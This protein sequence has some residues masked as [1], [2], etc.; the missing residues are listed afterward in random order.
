MTQ[1]SQDKA[2]QL[3]VL[4]LLSSFCSSLIFP[5]LPLAVLTWGNDAAAGGL[6]VSAYGFVSMCAA[7]LLGRMS[8]RIGQRRVLVG[9]YLVG[10]ISYLG[11]ASAA[12]LVAALIWRIVAGLAA[13][14]V[15]VLQAAVLDAGGEDKSKGLTQLSAFWAL[16]YV[17]GPACSA[18][19]TFGGDLA[20]VSLI[21]AGVTLVQMIW[22][23]ITIA[24][25]AQASPMAGEV[26]WRIQM[27]HRRLLV[28]LAS[29][30]VIAAVQAGLFAMAGYFCTLQLGWGAR[31][32]AILLVEGAFA[33][34]TF[35]FF[36]LRRM[37]AHFGARIA[38]SS[39]CIVGA[40]AGVV[41]ALLPTTGLVMAVATP[42]LF[43]A[44]SAAQTC[45]LSAYTEVCGETD[46]GSKMGISTMVTTLGQ[47]GGPTL[48]GFAMVAIAE[49]ALFFGAAAGFA[50]VGVGQ[51]ITYLL[52]Q[53]AMRHE[54]TRL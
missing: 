18:L 51:V 7:P 39:A 37:I 34:A 11:L 24:R 19:L 6:L 29:M 8:D 28:P 1:V 47:V 53:A 2:T 31:E 20:V 25:F 14:S 22:A 48:F 5:V 40:S 54:H 41:L 50:L 44:T 23:Q 45:L 3:A 35:Q 32:L 42:L 43:I 27:P 15:A 4:M 46:R 30:C 38:G 33:V 26:R 9:C 16:G 49:R 13:G 21:A 12:G 10:V 17:L 52:E 36:I